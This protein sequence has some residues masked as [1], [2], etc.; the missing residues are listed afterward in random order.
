MLSTSFG[1]GWHGMIVNAV[2]WPDSLR[3]FFF[4]AMI[5]LSD[6]PTLEEQEATDY[7]GVEGVNDPDDPDIPVDPDDNNPLPDDPDPHD[8]PDPYDDPIPGP[9]GLQSNPVPVPSSFRLVPPIVAIAPNHTS[10]PKPIVQLLRIPRKF[11]VV[12]SARQVPITIP[13]IYPTNPVPQVL[14]DSF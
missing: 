8:D 12:N 11:A 6:A 9:S 13:A 14:V 7:S 10:P 2:S 3:F 1:Q 5:S 4:Q